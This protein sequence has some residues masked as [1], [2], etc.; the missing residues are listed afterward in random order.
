VGYVGAGTVEFLYDGREFFFLEMNTRLQVEHPVTEMITGQDLVEWQLRVADGEPLP[1]KQFQLTQRGHAVEARLYAEDPE[2]GFLPSTGRIERL[3][4]PVGH[5]HVRVDTGVREGDEV[6]IHYDP[7]VAKVIAWGTD[8]LEAIERLRV[9]LEATDVDGL[10]TNTRFLWEILGHESVRAGDVST[11]L[12]ESGLPPSGATEADLQA[13][14]LIG[15]IVGSQVTGTGP[16]D[17]PPRPT[18]WGQRVGFRLNGPTS[19]RVPLALGS[20]RRWLRL[21]PAGPDLQVELDGRTHLL[22]GCTL[23]GEG[24][25][26][27]V[28]GQPFEA[29]FEARVDGFALRRQCLRFDFVEDPGADH[30]ASAEHEGHLRSPMPGLV[31]DVRTRA[32]DKVEAGA[33]LVV[34]EAMKMEHS[35]SAPWAGTVA[36]VAVKPGDRVEEGVELVVLEPREG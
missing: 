8:R 18:P 27:R 30:H 35:L 3:R 22:E 6:S 29:R 28:D 14:W 11:R 10:R 36:A 20:E 13:A 16:F 7:M 26:G 1:L 9:A 4:F 23:D 25:T 33:V 19:L 12:L 2:R 24:I 34:L 5:E 15:A 32:G 17:G 21:R 31:L